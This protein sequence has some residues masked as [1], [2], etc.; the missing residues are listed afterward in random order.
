MRR[1][2]G[3]GTQNLAAIGMMSAM[4]M[5]ALAQA[6]WQARG[7]QCQANLRNICL[8]IAMYETD[9]NDQFPETLQDMFQYMPV[10]KIFVCPND[11]EPMLIPD[12][13]KHRERFPNGGLKCS[14]YY[15][16]RL[17]P[18]VD[19][20]TIILYEKSGN[21]EDGRTV[22]FGDLH[23]ERLDEDTFQANMEESLRLVKEKN[24]DGYSDER[25]AEIG[26]FYAQRQ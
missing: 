5:P 21:H 8:A 23:A 14:Y 7:T 2:Y 10:P 1:A 24:W 18:P 11:P 19:P 3:L 6:R 4:M 17:S 26:A 15:V 22:A 16:G 20:M 13:L 12:S 9:Y 25:K